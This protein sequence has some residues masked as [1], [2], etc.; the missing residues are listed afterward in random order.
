MKSAMTIVVALL[1][2]GA[3]S[4]GLHGGDAGRGVSVDG[5]SPQIAVA[6][7]NV[8][9]RYC[10]GGGGFDGLRF[11]VTLQLTNLCLRPVYL[12]VDVWWE[13]GA[14]YAAV[15]EVHAA[16]A[17][18]AFRMD[19]SHASTTVAG[20]DVLA[21]L[22]GTTRDLGVTVGMPID[23]K[24]TFVKPGRYLFYFALS[25]WASPNPRVAR[26]ARSLMV[27]GKLKTGATTI[28]PIPF[29]VVADYNPEPCR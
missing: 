16:K 12:P 21:I 15:D 28:G 7:G 17:E 6:L 14:V 10:V 9:R 23:G 11:D 26:D 5:Q 25:F 3:I 4:C 2:L 20:A 22:P 24:G 8:T 1:L 27:R 19:L 18:W 13:V 29:D